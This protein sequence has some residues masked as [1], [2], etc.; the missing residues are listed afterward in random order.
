MAVK[1]S[2]GKTSKK[3]SFSFNWNSSETAKKNSKKAGKHVKKLGIGAIFGAIMLLCV[4]AFGGFVGCKI[5]TRK[6]CFVLNG[7]DEITLQI[8]ETYVNEGA[9]IVAFGKD[10][11]SEVL[12]ETNLLTN[13]DGEFYATEEG[14]YY[15]IYKS[16]NFKYGS[17]FKVQKIRLI[18]F[19]EAT[20]SEELTQGGNE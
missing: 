8:G 4:G 20:E 12:I 13:E 5:A 16:T 10:V 18:T 6:D 17:I 3:A 9:K 11:S 15:M 7:N 19:V 14:T 1:K 2:A